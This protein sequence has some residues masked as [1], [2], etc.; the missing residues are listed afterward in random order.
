MA[1][2][3]KKSELEIEREIK[4]LSK[5]I[6]AKGV[7]VRREKLVRGHSFRV[8]SGACEI[9]GQEHVFIDKRL[10]TESQV[11]ILLDAFVERNLCLEA[12]ELS[13]LSAR[14]KSILSSLTLAS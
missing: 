12:S 7:K 11:A 10:P 6:E 1:A 5:I 9:V 3:S 2:A 8:K 14:S 4:R 13:E